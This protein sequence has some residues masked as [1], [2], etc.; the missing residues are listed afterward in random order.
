MLEGS[1]FTE[2]YVYGYFSFILWYSR[3]L[4]SVKRHYPLVVS[5]SP[6]NKK[7]KEIESRLHLHF[8]FYSYLNPRLSSS[9]YLL[10]LEERRRLSKE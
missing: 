2:V 7:M 10:Y 4:P 3:R 8:Y 9:F 5:D 1:V 6:K